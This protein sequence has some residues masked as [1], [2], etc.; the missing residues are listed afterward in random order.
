MPDAPSVIGYG[1]AA[2]LVVA[3]LLNQRGL[4]RSG[5][6]RF[7][8]ANLLGSALIVVSLIYHPNWPSIVIEAFWSAISLCGVW[9]NCRTLR[10]AGR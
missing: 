8:A 4:L 1:G 3:Y 5:D 6:W 2:V 7:P 10:A 9:W